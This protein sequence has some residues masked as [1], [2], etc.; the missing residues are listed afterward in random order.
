MSGAVREERSREQQD[1]Q[2]SNALV[3]FIKALTQQH[4]VE[5]VL[6]LLADYCLE[7]LPVDGVG[8]LLL[9][10]QQLTV[11]TTNSKVGDAVERLEV[12]LEE[13]PCV[14]CVRVGHPVFVPDLAAA[15]DRYPNFAPR[16][17]EAGAGA[18]HALPMTGHGELVGSLNIVSASPRELSD[19]GLSTARMLCDVAVSYIFAVR[20][21]EETSELA[22][23]LQN[24]LD[25]RVLIEQ[26]KGIMSER[27]GDSMSD[28][29]E[30]LRKYARSR[31]M[32][33]RE[34]GRHAGGL[35]Y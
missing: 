2:V 3:E 25:T 22:G 17:L 14:E 12:E 35:T 4:T 31:N 26:A 29:F 1:E 9:E 8:V 34:Y 21:H 7:M 13:G 33:V 5:G 28:A 6:E 24:A 19:T 15:T 16:A 11:A 10:E 32:P 27:H 30:R 23:Q 18:I 20:L